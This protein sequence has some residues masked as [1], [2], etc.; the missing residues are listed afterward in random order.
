MSER[1]SEEL[2][3]ILTTSIDDY[4][5][6][7]QLNFLKFLTLSVVRYGLLED[8]KDV[9]SVYETIRDS[10]IRKSEDYRVAVSLLRHFLEITGCK[11]AAKLSAHCCEEFNLT[12][13]APS[14]SSYQLLFCLACKLVK[15]ENYNRL[16]ESIDAKKL[17]KPKYDLLDVT[18]P[19]ELFQSMI[20]KESLH[21]GN[22]KLLKQ[23]IVA[24]LEDA[25][26]E[27]ELEFVQHYISHSDGML[28]HVLILQLSL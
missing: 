25:Q 24:I 15:N 23:E 21:P 12:S 22:P 20:C 5:E 10:P 11:Q 7:Y 13:Y 16:F 26:L 14:V 19:V 1:A 4:S 27:Q 2:R 9:F 6:K 18:S 17:S 28:P 3:R 8:C